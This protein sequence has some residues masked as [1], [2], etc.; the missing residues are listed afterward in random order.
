M[1]SVDQSISAGLGGFLAL[2]VLAVVLWLLM[3]SMLRHMRIAA[4]NNLPDD[5]GTVTGASQPDS[6]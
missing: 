5:D 4:G 6:R 3:R 1:N 2:F